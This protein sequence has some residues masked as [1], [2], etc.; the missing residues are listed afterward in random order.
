MSNSFNWLLSTYQ[1]TASGVAVPTAD[2]ECNPGQIA[3]FDVLVESVSGSPSAASLACACQIAP[4]EALGNNIN[5]FASGGQQ[6]WQTVTA[7]DGFTGHLLLDGAWPTV[8]AD[9]TLAAWR[10]VSRR[11]LIPP[12]SRQARLSLT[13][14][15][16]G[17]SSPSFR[18]TVGVGVY[19]P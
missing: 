14:T 11:L 13:P 2:V 3:F 8:L 16:T 5:Y 1:L 15:F 19:T 7:A 10:S 9:Q 4:I 6:Q 18:V 12:V 17:G